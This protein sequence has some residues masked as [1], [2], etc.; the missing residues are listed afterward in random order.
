MEMSSPARATGKSRAESTISAAKV[1][2]PP[3]P[4]TPKELTVMMAMSVMMKPGS[5]GLTPTV[6]AIITASMA[7]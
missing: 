2:P 1:A 5:R 6:G 3:T 7:G 4:A